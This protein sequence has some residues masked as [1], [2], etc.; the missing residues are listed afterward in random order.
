MSE[1]FVDYYELLGVATDAESAQIRR[2]FLKLAAEH[3][4]D[5]GGST[6]D[7]QQYNKAYRTLMSESARKAYDLQHEFNTDGPKQYVHSAQ[8]EDGTAVDD[9]SDEEIDEFLDTIYAEY[10]AKP[11]EKKSFFSKF[12]QKL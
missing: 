2:A 7:M 1:G 8:N 10:R 3:H 9:L 11:K 5:V 4:P 12:K 6:E